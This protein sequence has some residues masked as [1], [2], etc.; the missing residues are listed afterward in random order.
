MLWWYR[1]LKSCFVEQRSGPCIVSKIPPDD[2]GSKDISRHGNDLVF[3]VGSSI[4][5]LPLE[6]DSGHICYFTNDIVC[7]MFI[8]YLTHLLFTM[9][10][11]TLFLYLTM[12]QHLISLAICVFVQQFRLNTGK[13]WHQS[14][15]LLALELSSSTLLD[16]VDD[17]PAVYL[18]YVLTHLSLELHIYVGEVGQQRFR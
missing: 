4:N 13:K 6:P 14:C 17:S 11:G 9:F 3:F 7:S 1:Y 18:C 10:K 16:L 15:S 2:T 12:S 8:I 5:C